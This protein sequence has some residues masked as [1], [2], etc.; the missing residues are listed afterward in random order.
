MNEISI[1]GL[2]FKYNRDRELF[3][4][5]LEINGVSK[6]EFCSKFSLSYSYVNAWGSNIK[7]KEKKFP[8][9]VFIYLKDIMYYKI[10]AIRVKVSLDILNEK[11]ASGKNLSEIYKEL[12]KK[13]DDDL[14][15]EYFG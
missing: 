12:N 14:L 4:K 13:V 8:T 7:G 6:K 1:N 10:S 3:N 11:L 5:L 9:W 15:Y 2:T